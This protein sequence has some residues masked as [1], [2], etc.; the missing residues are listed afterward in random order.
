MDNETRQ[1]IQRLERQLADAHQRV[2]QRPL[3]PQAISSASNP[4]IYQ[5]VGGNTA[6]S[7]SGDA[8]IKR[9]T[10]APASILDYDL[11]TLPTC[12]DGIGYGRNVFTGDLALI[13]LFPPALIKWDLWGPAITVLCPASVSILITSSSP[14]RYRTVLIPYTYM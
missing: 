13:G 10:A 6:L 3:W 14:A 7:P 1:H 8:G 9:I 2:D 11:T 4:A 5:I 12:I